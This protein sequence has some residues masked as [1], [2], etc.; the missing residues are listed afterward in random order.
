MSRAVNTSTAGDYCGR[1]VHGVSSL[2]YHELREIEAHRAKDRPTPWPH[3]A[4]R[5]GVN[6][7]DL[8]ALFERANDGAPKAPP[9]PSPRQP[10]SRDDRFRAMWEAGVPNLEIMTAL[11]L[12]AQTVSNIRDRLGLKKRGKGRPSGPWTRK[13]IA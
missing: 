9:P 11:R 8:R 6:E 5:Y 7:T 12:S 4:A 10:A 3:L 2:G 13:A 1:A